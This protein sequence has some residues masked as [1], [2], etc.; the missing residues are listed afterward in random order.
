MSKF[1]DFILNGL[2]IHSYPIEVK[3][4]RRRLKNLIPYYLGNT[5]KFEISIK[6]TTKGAPEL[7]RIKL[8]EK[9]HDYNKKQ[10]SEWNVNEEDEKRGNK[11]ANRIPKN[12]SHIA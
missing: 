3:E 6:R 12:K 8:F 7:W 1:R 5:V 11:T 4:W 9:I 10:L 2:E